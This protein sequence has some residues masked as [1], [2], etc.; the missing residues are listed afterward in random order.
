ML[1]YVLLMNDRPMEVVAKGDGT[2]DP[3]RAALAATTALLHSWRRQAANWRTGFEH[4]LQRPFWFGVGALLASEEHAAAL[5]LF[6]SALAVHAAAARKFVLAEVPWMPAFEFLRASNFGDV[7]AW[8]TR[9]GLPPGMGRS[10][11]NT[12]SFGFARW[13]ATTSDAS[14]RAA[15][16]AGLRAL[17]RDENPE[18]AVS[19]AL[20]VKVEEDWFPIDAAFQ[21]WI[22]AQSDA[23]G[24]DTQ[25]AKDAARPR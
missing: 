3:E 11:H 4:G 8:A 24:G 6:R 12:Q 16:E 15:F 18:P 21:A 1:L 9:Q 2:L 13:L 7:E 23:L 19:R 22:N 5:H 17:L 20:G 14:H 10:L 25:K